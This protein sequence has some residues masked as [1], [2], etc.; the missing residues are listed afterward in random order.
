MTDQ[1]LPP[2]AAI[3]EVTD[4]SSEIDR[5]VISL[6]FAIFVVL[7]AALTFGWTIWVVVTQFSKWEAILENHFAA[8]VGLPG[9]AAAAF[10]LVVF[11]RQTDGPIEFEFVGFKFKGASG[12][13][14]MWVICFWAIA[15]AIK[16]LW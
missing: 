4:P 3:P 15:G 9:A 1:T 6:G 5:K 10:A 13:V 11:L 7:G 2:A 8:I 12:Q 14:A 16:L